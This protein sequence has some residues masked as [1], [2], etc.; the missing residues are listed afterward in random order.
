VMS[1]KVKAA[2]GELLDLAFAAWSTPVGEPRPVGKAET[3]A[4]PYH[5]S[6]NR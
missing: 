4:A 2:A 5:L 3:A 6:A 1:S